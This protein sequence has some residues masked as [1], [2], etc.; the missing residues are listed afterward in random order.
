MKTIAE[1]SKEL[2]VTPQAVYKKLNKQFKQ[3]LKNHLHK[4]D[5]GETLIDKEGQSIL[6]DS[7]K[8][9]FKTVQQPVDST[10]N[11]LFNE[12][13]K[14]KDLQINALN[15]QIDILTKELSKSNEHIREISST[16]IELNRN[17]QVLL[18]QA[19]DKI[20]PTKSIFKK[21]FERKKAD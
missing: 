20:L 5:K 8:Q 19:Q 12:Q 1:L 9:A 13:L 18:K 15:A 14:S 2:N 4:G 7:F 17:N 10:V 16:L 21:L 6:S 3:Q 11:E